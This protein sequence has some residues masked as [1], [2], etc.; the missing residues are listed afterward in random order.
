MTSP[1][2]A[3]SQAVVKDIFF[4][5]AK[6]QV[7]D[8]MADFHIILCGT[9]R[10]EM[11]F[12]LA[13][14]QTHHRNFDIL[15]LTNKLA[16]SS[17]IDSVLLRNPGLDAGSRRLKTSGVLGTDHVNP[18]SWT[19][20]VSVGRV[21]LQVCWEEGRTQAAALVLSVYP[22]DPILDFNTLFQHPNRDL[23]RPEGRYI[24]VSNEV[25]LSLDNEIPAQTSPNDD[26][27]PVSMETTEVIQYSDSV[28]GGI[29]GSGP[30]EAAENQDGG[31]G[32]ESGYRD[33]EGIGLED[34][35]PDSTDEPLDGYRTNP[36]EWLEIDG[37]RY[38]K[39]SI[40]AQYLKANRSK[41]VVERTLR[42]RGLTLDDLRKHH[43]TPPIGEDNFQVGDLA[44]TLVWTGEI[45]CLI[46]FQATAIRKDR[47]TQHIIS[48]E[49][50]AKQDSGYRVEGQVLHLVQSNPDLWV[51]LPHHFS[52]VSKPK[53]GSACRKSGIRD[54]TL[55][56][57]GPLCYRASPDITPISQALPTSSPSSGDLRTWTF[58][59]RQL[60]DLSEHIWAE[61][62][63]DVH[64]NKM[65]DKV[66]TLPRVWD[67]REFPYKNLSG[68]WLNFG[69][70]DWHY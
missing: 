35:L 14:T 32:Y 54:F 67:S 52:K 12:C 18:K 29:G 46:I 9:D 8:P 21:S 42:V 6:Q 53:K 58:Y 5:V 69:S 10:L 22:E 41:K 70:T 28:V 26:G 3:D 30:D 40:I 4:C 44:A 16:T 50:L 2:Y 43:S 13:R 57:Q 64:P 55:T 39:A 47:S 66:E 38:H 60:Q 65:L 37:Q 31:V 19:G 59:D 45:V 20:D 34:L 7:L 27:Q 68:E 23:L 25:D 1:L 63:P 62:A 36:E 56:V 33:D 17:L 11:D 48:T 15:D 49:T 61:F 51:W 24:G